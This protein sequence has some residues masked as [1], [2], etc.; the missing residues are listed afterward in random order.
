MVFFFFSDSFVRRSTVVA[1][2]R[3][4]T[5]TR[6]TVSHCPCN[7]VLLSII[8]RKRTSPRVN[9][10]HGKKWSYD[11]RRRRRRRRRR[12]SRYAAP[13]VAALRKQH[14]LRRTTVT[15]TFSLCLSSSVDRSSIALKRECRCCFVIFVFSLP[16]PI[17]LFI[18][19][20]VSYNERGARY[21]YLLDFQFFFIVLYPSQFRFPIA[22]RR[23]L[24]YHLW[25]CCDEHRW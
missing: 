16:Y 19:I 11:Q 13:F 24:Y 1:R 9:S 23:P 2:F 21:Y 12:F 8:A 7:I 4:I 22:R 3:P 6:T 14:L 25:V 20:S 15:P 5:A 10:K 18:C 17:I